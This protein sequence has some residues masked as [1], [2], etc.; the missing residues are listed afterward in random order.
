[1]KDPPRSPSTARGRVG[2]ATLGLTLVVAAVG[3]ACADPE[4]PRS[5][6]SVPL[7]AAGAEWRFLD[8]GSDPGEVWTHLDYDD[9][10]WRSGPAKLGYGEG[11]EATI[12]RCRPGWQLGE[13]C[14]EGGP[15]DRH[16]ATFFRHVFEVEDPAAFSRLRLRL[17]KDDGAV[18]Y[19]NGRPVAHANLPPGRP[20]FDAYAAH[21][22]EDE[23]AWTDY[24]LEPGRLLSKGRNV[25]AVQLHQAGG[26]SDDLA[27]DLELRAFDPTRTAL[28]RSPYLQLATTSSAVVRWRTG[29]PTP[30]AVVYGTDPDDLSQRARAPGRSLDHEVRLDGLEPG[31][32]YYYAVEAGERRLAGGPG[33]TFMVAPPPGFGAAIRFWVLGDSGSA[34]PWAARVR[35]AY[36]SYTQGRPADLLLMLGDNAYESGTDREYQRAVF[37]M[38]PDILARTFLW[39]ALGNHDTRSSDAKDGEGPYF[40]SFTLP[41][42]GEAG[43]APSGRE[44][45]YSFDWG[46]VHVVCLDS[47]GSDLRAGKPQMRW[48]EEDLAT[49]DRRWL[50]AFWHHPPYTKG[51]HDSDDP[52][53]WQM[54]AM[55]ENALPLLEAAGV[56]LVLTGHSHSYERSHLLAGHYGTSET[57]E[58]GMVLDGG[59]GRP[60]GDGPYRKRGRR[61]AVYV[62]AGSGGRVAQATF[63]HPVMAVEHQVRGSLVIDVQG[64][65]LDAA[66]VDDAGEVLD[67]FA[68]VKDR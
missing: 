43:G 39:P 3:L 16:P 48:L 29:D 10:G 55:R 24:R 27:F 52:G 4:P 49:Q 2:H 20:G 9:D 60:E 34:D 67:R 65:R 7:V 50:I 63:G 36:R 59:D 58:P 33:H 47:S 15:D 21:A 64:E 28:V 57:L 56:D 40:D 62:V 51:W 11:D 42:Q 18:V 68:M 22:V 37:E 17:L 45:W 14:P 46:D 66:F 31:V 8:D 26:G 1:M 44:A 25:L 6:A 38:Y 13:P 53:G 35:N 5:G 30:S 19:L 23:R 54:Q 12:V 41:T 61:G 32:R